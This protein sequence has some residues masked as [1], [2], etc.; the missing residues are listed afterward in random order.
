LTPGAN[1]AKLATLV[2]TVPAWRDGVRNPPAL[3]HW[4]ITQTRATSH[5]PATTEPTAT[6]ST[7]PPPAHSPAAE[8][9]SP[10]QA[11]AWAR[12][13]DRHNPQHRVHAKLEFSHWGAAVDHALA[14][15]FPGLLDKTRTAAGSDGR[16]DP[17]TDPATLTELAAEVRRL[18]PA[19]AGFRPRSTFWRPAV[20]LGIPACRATRQS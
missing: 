1:P 6:P 17:S 2:H 7:P 14:R 18:D 13:P 3:A 15:S 20:P 8:E 4:A 12:E 16:D 19:S 9:S 11:L 10:S 5:N